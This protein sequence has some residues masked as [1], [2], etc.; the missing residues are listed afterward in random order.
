MER[1][2]LSISSDPQV[3]LNN[4]AKE[5]DVSISE[6]VS[7]AIDSF[8]L[9][10]IEEEEEKELELLAEAVIESNKKTIN[11]L[12]EAHKA[13]QDTLAHFSTSKR[14]MMASQ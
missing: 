10:P 14:I 12:E 9:N 8:Q 13:V 11:S 6:I 4:L 5:A 2:T 7:R 1:A 3:K